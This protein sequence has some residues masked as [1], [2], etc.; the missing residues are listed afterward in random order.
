MNQIFIILILLFFPIIQVNSQTV[1][2]KDIGMA[3]RRFYLSDNEP[4]QKYKQ[5]TDLEINADYINYSSNSTTVFDDALY[6]GLTQ[7][8]YNKLVGTIVFFNT[9]FAGNGNLNSIVITIN[10]IKCDIQIDKQEF[11]AIENYLRK[12]DIVNFKAPFDKEDHLLFQKKV[13]CGFEGTTTIPKQNLPY[14]SGN[15]VTK[16]WPLNSNVSFS[17]YPTTSNMFAA[18]STQGYVYAKFEKAGI[19]NVA[20]V[21]TGNNS[22]YMEY[23]VLTDNLGKIVDKL[24]ISRVYQS[25]DGNVILTQSKFAVDGIIT[26]YTRVMSEMTSP[27]SFTITKNAHLDTEIFEIDV[28]NGKFTL[29]SSKHGAQRSYNRK[30]VLNNNIWND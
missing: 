5:K 3:Q 27:Q 30:Q 13:L 17:I 12:A 1:V 21:W 6:F 8:N 22:T 20:A 18:T 26:R 2:A 9:D 28:E 10:R 16:S 4:N 19:Y 15:I 7:D 24:L 29:K 23:L 14:S 11:I 25:K